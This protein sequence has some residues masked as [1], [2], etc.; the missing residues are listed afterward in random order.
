MVL[1][2]WLVHGSDAPRAVAIV[3]RECAVL[4]VACLVAFGP[5][6]LAAAALGSGAWDLL[7]AIAG[8]G[9]Y[10]VILRGALPEHAAIAHRMLAPL[11]PSHRRPV[12][13]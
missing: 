3:V 9:L 5:V 2:M 4:D 8:L 13:A 1:M 11:L 10:A 7:A 12:T 6:G